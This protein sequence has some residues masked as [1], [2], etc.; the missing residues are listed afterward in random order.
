M[1]RIIGAK[2]SLLFL[3]TLSVWRATRVSLVKL[4]F[5]HY[6]SIHALRVESD[7]NTPVIK[8]IKP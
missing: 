3:S 2:R 4:F 8:V 1:S 7:E 6:I 5:R